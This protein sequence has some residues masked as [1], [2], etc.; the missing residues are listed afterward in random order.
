MLLETLHAD[1]GAVIDANPSKSQKA[2]PMIEREATPTIEEIIKKK[3]WTWNNQW[4]LKLCF[5]LFC[6]G[7]LKQRLLKQGYCM[8]C[9][10]MWQWKEH[11]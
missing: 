8:T 2:P 11:G 7:H 5:V 4:H 3:H 6:Y 9:Q 1:A 10:I